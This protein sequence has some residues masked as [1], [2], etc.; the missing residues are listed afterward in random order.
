LLPR[1]LLASLFNMDASKKR[2]LNVRSDEPCALA[3]AKYN[4][5]PLLHKGENFRPTDLRSALA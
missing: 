3:S 5:A 1:G 2:Q 4:D